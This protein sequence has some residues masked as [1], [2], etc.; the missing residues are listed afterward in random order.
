[1]YEKAQKSLSSSDSRVSEAV[2]YFFQKG[3]GIS[4]LVSLLNL[5]LPEMG[6]RPMLAPQSTDSTVSTVRASPASPASPAALV[7]PPS[8]LQLK[9]DNAN[10]AKDAFA[11][12]TITSKMMI[13]ACGDI[14]SHSLE[15][16]NFMM[17][18]EAQDNVNI[19]AEPQQQPT[20]I[21]VPGAFPVGPTA[22]M[23]EPTGHTYSIDHHNDDNDV[24]PEESGTAP[25]LVGHLAPDEEDIRARYQQQLKTELER[26]RQ[27]LVA[28]A[29][30][31]VAD[32][33]KTADDA[34]MRR[35]GW[36]QRMKRRIMASVLIL[37]VVGAGLGGV[38]YWVLQDDEEKGQMQ[39][40]QKQQLDPLV[41]ELRSFIAPTDDDLLPFSDPASAQSKAVAWLHDDP[42]TLT[43]GR[44]AATVLERYVL[45]VFKYSTSGWLSPFLSRSESVCRWNGVSCTNDFVTKVDLSSSGIF[46]AGTVPWE[47]VLLTN[48]KTL[49]F[50]FSQFTGVIPT[51]INELTNL[52]NLWMENKLFWGPLLPDLPKTLISLRFHANDFTGS[53]PDVWGSSLTNLKGLLINENQL[54]GTIPS[55]LGQISSL[56]RF[57]FGSNN[58][59][60]SVDSFLCTGRI[61]SELIA[62]CDKVVCTCCT[63]C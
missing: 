1:M 2:A 13:D 54:T 59:T 25:I 8:N 42:I 37:V 28:D 47:L 46:I 11:T 12:A 23:G 50:S 30:I 29:A 39:K 44:S 51:R 38:V 48:L 27:E 14:H 53:I 19:V 16:R 57:E 34:P 10:M 56:T 9:S 60:G 4:C 3:S 6:R 40:G 58:I 52:E 33:V 26:M 43:P 15:V 7:E 21:T 24:S 35:C 5:L 18:L 36:S 49:D 41:E 61:W 22:S 55:S 32:E 63:G 45:A 20:R 17:S 31:V 62:D